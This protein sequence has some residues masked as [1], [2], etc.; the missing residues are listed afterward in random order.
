MTGPLRS[1]DR[2]DCRL[3]HPE[4]DD[5]ADIRPDDLASLLIAAAMLVIVFVVCFVMLPVMA[6]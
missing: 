3:C 1:C 2:D 5:R 4:L 6:P